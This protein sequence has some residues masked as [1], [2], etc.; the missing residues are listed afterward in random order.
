[1]P[2]LKPDMRNVYGEKR[3]SFEFRIWIYNVTLY[4]T[5]AHIINN[6]PQ[7]DETKI[8]H[9]AT[10]LAITAAETQHTLVSARSLLLF[11]SSS[12][13]FRFMSYSC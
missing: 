9:V 13:V 11:R 2:D 3:D 12:E 6:T 5:L 1:M 8:K 7:N 10:Y 4:L